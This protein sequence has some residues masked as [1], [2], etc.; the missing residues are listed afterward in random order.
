[1][2]VG[3]KVMQ[4]LKEMQQRWISK[5]PIIISRNEYRKSNKW[6]YEMGYDE[7]YT[8]GYQD[9]ERERYYEF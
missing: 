2:W 1:M 4:K 3:K 7:G 9:A 6:A 8:D 5:I